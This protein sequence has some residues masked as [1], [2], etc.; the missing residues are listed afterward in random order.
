MACLSPFS[1]FCKRHTGMI[2]LLLFGS[3]SSCRP[4][5]S[6][7][8][9]AMHADQSSAEDARGRRAG[10]DDSRLCSS[11][12]GTV[13][14]K[15]RKVTQIYTETGTEDGKPVNAHLF[16]SPLH[17]CN[18]YGAVEVQLHV[19]MGSMQRPG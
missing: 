19:L 2:T 5:S 17:K 11:V 16:P 15:T 18:G 7:Y 6:M 9:V 14:L 13:L 12:V 3:V 10:A 1:C 4:R 8:G